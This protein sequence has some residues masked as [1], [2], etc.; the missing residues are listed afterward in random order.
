MWQVVENW[1]YFDRRAGQ[2]WFRYYVADPVPNHIRNLRG[3]CRR[4]GSSQIILT[5][6]DFEPPFERPS[7]PAEWK[8]AN[9]GAAALLANLVEHH[10]GTRLSID[11]G[12]L[13]PTDPSGGGSASKRSPSVRQDRKR[14]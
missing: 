14:R 9:Q 11:R 4:N 1:P 6:F 5:L 2:R 8:V 7:F 10:T 12:Y 3:G 13:R